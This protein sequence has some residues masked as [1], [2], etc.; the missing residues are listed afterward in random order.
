MAF[1]Q[2]RKC[3]RSFEPWQ[4]G[5]NRVDWLASLPQL[6]AYKMSDHLGVGVCCKPRASQLELIAQF[7]M[8]FDDAVVDDSNATNRVR[9]RVPFVCT[10][11]SRPTRVADA[12]QA[13]EWLAG[14]FALKIYE[15]PDR[16]PAGKEAAFKCGDTG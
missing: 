7:A 4:R 3:E 5:A 16:A 15:F 2:E 12:Y 8:I 6:L 11:M 10:A 13:G 1:K 9:M 14:E